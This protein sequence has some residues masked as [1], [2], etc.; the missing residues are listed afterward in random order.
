MTFLTTK[1]QRP[2]TKAAK[3]SRFQALSPRVPSEDF[4][5]CQPQREKDEL[6]SR[7]FGTLPVKL[8]AS[9]SAFLHQQLRIASMRRNRAGARAFAPDALRRKRVALWIVYR[10]GS[11][12]LK[13]RVADTALLTQRISRLERDGALFVSV[14]SKV[15]R[16]FAQAL[17]LP[18]SRG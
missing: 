1:P 9:R 16:R 11:F 17:E 3:K 14:E 13:E 7:N 4:L 15:S 6:G 18:V 5:P 8:T 12:W 2:K 10:K